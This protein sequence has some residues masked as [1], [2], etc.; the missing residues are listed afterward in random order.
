MGFPYDERSVILHTDPRSSDEYRYI[1]Q[2][3]LNYRE[4][5]QLV[6]S[7]MM[8]GQNSEADGYPLVQSGHSERS[9]AR[10]HKRQTF[11][12]KVRKK[13]APDF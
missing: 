4:W 13:V 11:R 10:M 7:F 6:L 1:A 2:G 9:I 12:K 5:F 3:A 8:N